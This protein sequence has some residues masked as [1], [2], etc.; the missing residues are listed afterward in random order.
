MHAEPDRAQALAQSL[1]YLTE[2]DLCSLC[3]ITVVTAEAWRKRH[4]GPR[5]AIAGNSILYPREAVREFLD[6]QVRARA[7]SAKDLL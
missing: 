1:D 4:K 7:S 6:S 5:Y 3:G 2:K